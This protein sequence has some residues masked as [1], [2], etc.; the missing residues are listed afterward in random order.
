[1]PREFTIAEARNHFS[2]VVRLAED[3]GSVELTR[4]GKTVAVMVST[5]EFQ[6]LCSPAA[7]PFE[8]LQ[9]FRAEHD[10]DHNGLET[11][12][13]EGLRDPSPGRTVLL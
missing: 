9:T 4:R 12:D 8:F 3:E 6:R 11:G 7:S 5:R 1:M 2:E 13:L 10:A